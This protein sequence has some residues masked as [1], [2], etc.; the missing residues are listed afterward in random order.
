MGRRIKRNHTA[1]AKE[2]MLFS[3]L[4]L[5]VAAVHH[6]SLQPD[7]DGA[8]DTSFFRVAE[9][10]REN[11]VLRKRIT[12]LEQHGHIVNVSHHGPSKTVLD[13]ARILAV[14]GP[15]KRIILTFV[16]SIRLDFSTTWVAHVR[17]LGMT[18]WLVG[19]TDAGALHA[20]LSAGTPTFDMHTSLPTG[21]WAWGSPQ[22][23]S[24]GPVKV[25]LIHQALTC[26][27][28]LIITDVDALVLREPFGYMARWP[29]AGFLTT[30]D[31]LHNATD[32][33]GL[34]THASIHSAFNIGYMFFRPSSLV[35]LPVAMPSCCS[36]PCCSRVRAPACAAHHQAAHN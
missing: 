6:A 26:G 35:R 4:A 22:F 9:L 20:L 1:M 19:A 2:A 21:E 7:V 28:E 8:S 12:E 11:G 23:K 25:R 30:S 15:Q 32:D 18:N 14:A 10:E 24:L 31:H 34:E 27:V 17:R 33:D 16:N 13:R 3:L 5:R 36:S 29:D